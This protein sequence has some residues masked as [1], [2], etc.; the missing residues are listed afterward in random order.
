MLST[1]TAELEKARAELALGRS[2][3]V[4]D[5]QA[6]PLLRAALARARSCGA[7]QVLTD[8]CAALQQRG[9]HVDG[10]DR[11]DAPPVPLTV[12]RILD[13]AGAGLGVHEVAQRLF[14]T[15]GIVRA[16]LDAHDHS[17]PAQAGRERVGT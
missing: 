4:A 12:R 1:T 2:P 10:E 6:V 17:S 5:A 8:A 9:E 3:D 11:D 16:A 13:L 14:L 7:Q 15:P